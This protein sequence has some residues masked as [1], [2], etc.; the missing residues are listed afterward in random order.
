VHIFLND[1]LFSLSK[2]N[3]KIDILYVFVG[4]GTFKFARD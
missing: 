4:G 1:D 3:R 2:M